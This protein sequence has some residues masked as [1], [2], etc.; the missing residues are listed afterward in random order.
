M[1]YSPLD[2]Q[3]PSDC[4][5]LLVRSKHQWIS[6]ADHISSNKGKSQ[7]DESNWIFIS[8]FPEFNRTAVGYLRVLIHISPQCVAGGPAL[9]EEHQCS[10]ECPK[11]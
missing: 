6:N 7:W 8:N 5:N 10:N 9:G 4:W 2:R 11:L 1:A 3:R